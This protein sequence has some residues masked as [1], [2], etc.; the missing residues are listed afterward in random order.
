MI[1]VL[2]YLHAR[3]DAFVWSWKRMIYI[4]REKMWRLSLVWY[5]AMTQKISCGIGGFRQ[6]DSSYNAV[7]L[8]EF[9][10]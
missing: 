9:D 1:Y 5:R 2:C 10:N 6:W 4:G 8:N 7:L 3:G